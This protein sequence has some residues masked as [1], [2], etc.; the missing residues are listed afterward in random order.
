M[1][2]KK[3]NIK[4]RLTSPGNPFCVHSRG[5]SLPKHK[6]SSFSIQ[7][8][9]INSLA[10]TEQIRAFAVYLKMKHV[11]HNSQF[12][13]FSI[14]RHH[15]RIGVSPYMLK[16]YLPI[17]EEMGLIQW[18]GTTLVASSFKKVLGKRSPNKTL[19][20][21]SVSLKE[22]IDSIRFSVIEEDYNKQKFMSDMG[23][24]RSGARGSMQSYKKKYAKYGHLS[25]C[26]EKTRTS[27][28]RISKLCKMSTSSAFSKVQE[29]K[30][31]GMIKMQTDYQ[32]L[33]K[34]F[35]GEFRPMVIDDGLLV[36]RNKNL[37][38]IRGSIF[39]IPNKD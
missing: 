20:D 35:K 24:G 15:A 6:S 7:Q 5:F 8:D 23:L 31:K 26:Q 12:L 21:A 33:E 3:E 29:W 22:V 19:I 2:T 39:S 13:N 36:L 11:Y 4:N 32:I 16:K 27:Y 38:L 9:Y 1:N 17:M 28:R 10:S 14:S 25:K 30:R 37:V 34:A 18:E